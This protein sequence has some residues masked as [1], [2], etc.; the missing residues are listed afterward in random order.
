MGVTVDRVSWVQ[1]CPVLFGDE[2]HAGCL[3]E[4][5]ARSRDGLELTDGEYWRLRTTPHCCTRGCLRF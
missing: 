5:V 4:G 1:Q 3:P 2:L